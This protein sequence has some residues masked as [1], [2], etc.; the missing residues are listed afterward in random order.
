M[1]RAEPPTRVSQTIGP[2]EVKVILTVFWEIDGFHV[3][4]MMPPGAFQHRVVP[5]SYDT[6]VTGESFSGGREKPCTLTE[7]PLEQSSGS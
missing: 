3:V 1:A 5:Y 4:D 2:K 7:R 6:S